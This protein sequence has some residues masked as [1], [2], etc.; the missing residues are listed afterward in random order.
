MVRTHVPSIG[1]PPPG[2][3]LR[4]G[5]RRPALRR[6]GEAHGLCGEADG[7]SLVDRGH[8]LRRRPAAGHLGAS[9]AQPLTQLDTRAGAAVGLALG[10][11]GE[12]NEAS[13]AS[14]RDDHKPAIAPLA[15]RQRLAAEPAP[16]AWD[17][18]G[19]SWPEAVVLR[20]HP[21]AHEAAE[22]GALAPAPREAGAPQIHGVVELRQ[23]APPR[24]HSLS[25]IGGFLGGLSET[26]G[27]PLDQASVFWQE[28]KAYACTDKYENDGGVHAP[29]RRRPDVLGGVEVVATPVDVFDGLPDAVGVQPHSCSQGCAENNTSAVDPRSPHSADF[30]LRSELRSADFSPG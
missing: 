27:D 22:Q 16:F 7:H 10:G 9:A 2:Y 26:I 19:L 20:G 30:E 4:S 13:L 29:P 24:L 15:E 12:I 11:F 25:V 21:E 14:G 17:G 23:K 18:L 3:R 6:R 1:N 28:P 5:R 8:P